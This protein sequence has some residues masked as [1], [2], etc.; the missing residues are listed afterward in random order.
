MN[1]VGQFLHRAAQFLF[2]D[3]PIAQTC[4]VVVPFAK[5]A[6]V[7]HQHFH[8]HFFGGAG[9]A[10]DFFGVKI[11]I[12][13][14][15]AVDQH[16][17]FG[18]LPAG[19]NHLMTDD[20]VVMAAQPVQAVCAVRQKSFRRLERF[21]RGQRPGKAIW[22][23][24]GYQPGAARLI[25]FHFFQMVAGIHKHTAVAIAGVFG[26]VTVAQD[27]KGIAVV[28]AH[29]PAGAE[30]RN[31]PGQAQPF[32]DTFHA[33]AAMEVDHVKIAVQ[34]IHAGGSSLFDDQRLIPRI[35]QTGGA[36]DHILGWENMIL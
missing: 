36:D 17:P 29:A 24:T 2:V 28:A 7:Q 25:H 20:I 10:Q 26:G 15:P 1:L 30:G 22:M 35:D 23:N 9:K 34:K 19:R 32:R 14:F 33:V 12:R 21:A 6:V 16:R 4:V 11:K 3:H 27:H 31:A 18:R 8:A 5:P 13:R